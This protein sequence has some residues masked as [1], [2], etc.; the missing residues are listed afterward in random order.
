MGNTY[1][2]PYLLPVTV[3]R[4]TATITTTVDSALGRTD[5]D[6]TTATAELA[7][8][9]DVRDR[10]AATIRTG[11]FFD[12]TASITVADDERLS[13][14]SSDAT[15]RLGQA[16]S[17]VLGTVA[18]VAGAAAGLGV[19]VAALAPEHAAAFAETARAA[20]ID[21]VDAAY[22]VAHPD[23]HAQ[24]AVYKVLLRD[25]R[26]KIALALGQILAAETMV[27]R[28]KA[29]AKHHS[30]VAA[31]TD[32]ESELNRMQALFD[33]WRAGTKKATTEQ[34]VYEVPVDELPAPADP[35]SAPPSAPPSGLSP[36]AEKVWSEL[37]MLVTVSDE[38][39][40]ATAALSQPDGLL[41]STEG[42]WTRV[43]RRVRW[44]LWREHLGSEGGAGGAPAAHIEKDGTSTVVDRK[45]RHLCVDFR[46]SLFSRRSV[47]ATFSSGGVLTVLDVGATS[48]IADSAAA[49]SDATA[50]ISAGLQNAGTVATSV[51]SLRDRS[52]TESVAQA[53][54][55]L[56]LKQAQLSLAGLDATDA[57]YAELARLKQE[58]EL[59]EQNAKLKAAQPAQ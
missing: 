36:L 21:P 22:E 38:E 24:L 26:A 10:Y 32:I 47:K 53:K 5:R 33:A 19:R 34:V 44:A 43:P 35:P 16:V 3:V 8:A 15:G 41:R 58:V 25:V 57:D 18:T 46:R 27:E 51:S 52:L 48:T 6:V 49:V 9:G 54:A 37:G 7:V 13:S 17:S 59:A 28:G 39:A 40:P 31:R 14:A 20:G 42:I 45:S 55:K 29:Q 23:E 4:F 12:V 50:K 2:V 56:D 11:M 1:T 30:L